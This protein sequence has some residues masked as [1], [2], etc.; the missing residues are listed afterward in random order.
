MRV[1]IRW[2]WAISGLI[3]ALLLVGVYLYWH[4][5]EIYP[6]TDDAYVSAHVV[7]VAPQITGPIIRVYVNNQQYVRKGDPLFDID[8]T[9]FRLA[10]TQAQAR[11]VLARQSVSA[12][13]AALAAAEA[14]RADRQVTMHNTESSAERTRR[15]R[16]KGFVSAQA[17]DNAEAAV[18]S[19]KAQLNLAVAKV[20]QAQMTLGNTGVQNER[21]RNAMADVDR[22][23][24]DLG[25][26]HVA[27]ACSGHVAE[28]TL[29]PGD[30]VQNGTALF[31]LVC[32]QQ[33]WVN[34]N[35]K[36]TELGR[37]RPGQTADISVDM[38]PSHLF[39]GRVEN[40]SGASGTAFSLLPPENATGNWVKVTQ[41]VPVRVVVIDP[42]SAY[43]LR[44]G[45]SAQVTI[46]TA[47]PAAA[48]IQ[49][50][51]R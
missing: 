42:D 50:S 28:L 1:L 16:D 14:E 27:A 10:L 11:L 21:I 6:S 17:Y 51:R 19:A 34:A 38:Y 5:S 45:T 22:A 3:A 36:E 7:Q 39:H 35:F 44:V 23:R 8:Q 37:I 15:L 9:S 4:H 26:T 40:I 29:H 48:P 49:D 43:P 32:D 18:Q 13:A 30:V 46:D 12:D 31:T 25:H 47:R 20:R 2:K 41:R 24:L 33:F